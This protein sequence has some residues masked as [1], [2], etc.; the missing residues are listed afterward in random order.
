MEIVEALRY[1][2]RTFGIPVD[3]PAEVFCDDKSAVKNLIVQT[4]N[5]EKNT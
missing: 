3:G 4:S 2:L 1:T 5:S